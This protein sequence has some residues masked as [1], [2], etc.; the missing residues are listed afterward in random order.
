MNLD[1]SNP[2]IQVNFSTPGTIIAWNFYSIFNNFSDKMMNNSA[3]DGN[4]LKWHSV[5][6]SS[7]KGRIQNETS[8]YQT[9]WYCDDGTLIGKHQEV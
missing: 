4:K 5:A 8:S 9:L 2:Y 6:L 1:F 7:I 3:A